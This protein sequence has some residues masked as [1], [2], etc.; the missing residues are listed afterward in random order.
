MK[1]RTMIFIKLD[2]QALIRCGSYI[3]E[4]LYFKCLCKKHWMFFNLKLDRYQSN[5]PSCANVVY[6]KNY[7][8]FF[9]RRISAYSARALTPEIKGKLDFPASPLEFAFASGREIRFKHRLPLN[10]SLLRRAKTHKC[11]LVPR[12]LI[13]RT[14]DLNARTKMHLHTIIGSSENLVR[15]K[16]SERCY[17]GG[18][19]KPRAII[20]LE[21][22][23]IRQATEATLRRR[24]QIV[25]VC[26]KYYHGCVRMTLS[27]F[28]LHSLFEDERRQSN[29]FIFHYFFSLFFPPLTPS[30]NSYVPVY[31][32]VNNDGFSLRHF[33]SNP[34]SCDPRALT[35]LSGIKFKRSRTVVISEMNYSNILLIKANFIVSL[36]D[37]AST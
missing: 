13:C 32:R 12:H 24:W 25:S 31:R 33:Q 35:G 15:N 21:G 7:I 20:I 34:L 23:Q 37:W 2:M 17:D 28:W 9:T 18:R 14:G 11:N 19:I 10:T 3:N 36:T 4:N 6:G 30:S 29:R 27:T 5:F 26:L 16:T 8:F 1:T 22:I